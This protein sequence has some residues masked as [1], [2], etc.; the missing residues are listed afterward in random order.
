MSAAEDNFVLAVQEYVFW[1]HEAF[2][3]LVKRYE[4]LPVHSLRLEMQCESATLRMQGAYD[5]LMRYEA[6]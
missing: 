2:E 1:S 3:L 5:D 6:K 4:E